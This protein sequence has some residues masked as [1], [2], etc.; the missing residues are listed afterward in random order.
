LYAATHASGGNVDIVNEMGTVQLLIHKSSDHS[1]GSNMNAMRTVRHTR[2]VMTFRIH[3]TGTTKNSRRS[4]D[5]LAAK[6]AKWTRMRTDRAAAADR[7]LARST[8]NRGL[9]HGTPSVGLSETGT[10]LGFQ[11]RCRMRRREVLPW[12]AQ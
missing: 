1:K 8:E 12:D 7:R 4:N 10:W 2:S 9:V 5:R 11:N 6:L 3:E